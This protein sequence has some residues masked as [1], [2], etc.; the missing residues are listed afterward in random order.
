MTKLHFLSARILDLT[1]AVQRSLGTLLVVVRTFPV[2][3]SDK[4][5]DVTT[6]YRGGDASLKNTTEDI[7]DMQED[8]GFIRSSVMRINEDLSSEELK[9]IDQQIF[10]QQP[11]D[12]C[13]L[14][15]EGLIVQALI[16]QVAEQLT[17]IV[18][19]G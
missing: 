5:H 18:Q 10:L 13:Y 6:H 14:G 3:R 11:S 19:S 8:S 16:W 2:Y 1:S 9:C 7:P 15:C 4:C 12:V 17:R